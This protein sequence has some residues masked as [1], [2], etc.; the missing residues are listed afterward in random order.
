MLNKHTVFFSFLFFLFGFIGIHFHEMWRDELQPWAIV[1][2]SSSFSELWF[3]SRYDARPIL[4]Y[5][6]LFFLSKWTDNMLFMQWSH[7]LFAGIAAFIFLRYAPFS[8]TDKLLIIFGYFFIYE[9]TIISRVYV[10]GILLLFLFC[11]VC[12]R[13]SKPYLFLSLIL[14]FLCLNNVF[15]CI[16]GISLLVFWLYNYFLEKRWFIATRSEKISVAISI[17]ISI[18]GIISYVLISMPPTDSI[19]IEDWNN[20]FSLNRSITILTTI[21]NSFIPIPDLKTYQFWN[22]NVIPWINLKAVLSFLI[23]LFCILLFVPKKQI[24]LLYLVGTFG[25]MMFMYLKY[26]GYLRHHGHLFLLFIACLW[27]EKNIEPSELRWKIL[28]NL[29]C[30]AQKYKTLF[31]RSVL[32]IHLLVGIYA[33]FIEIKHPFS[34][35]KTTANFIIQNYLENKFIIGNRDVAASAVAVWLRKP[36]YYIA[37]DKI[38]S[39]VLFDNKRKEYEGTDEIKK[40]IEVMKSKN[41]RESIWLL[42]HPLSGKKP[43]ELSVNLLEKF[44]TSIVA[45]EIYYIYRVNLIN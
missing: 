42:N 15:I 43:K 22:S 11:A 6:Y 28:N 16:I 37:S 3:N 13:P 9:Y 34:A 2:A 1:K 26:H 14:F 31:I 35:S 10:M 29:S 18:A 23:V 45:D 41:I 17:I 5:G 21:W 19:F 7:L 30:F 36:I 25:L 12:S 24:L 32:G 44:E 40:T 8:L 38:I 33:Y 20:F 39:Y 27:L 4:W